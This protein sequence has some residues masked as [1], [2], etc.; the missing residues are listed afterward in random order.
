MPREVRRIYI[1]ITKS[2]SKNPVNTR[3]LFIGFRI[4][5]VQW[6]HRT[7]GHAVTWICEDLKYRKQR[8]SQNA[9]KWRISLI[10]KIQEFRRFPAI[11]ITGKRIPNKLSFQI[12]TLYLCVI[13]CFRLYNY[14]LSRYI[15]C[16]HFYFRRSDIF[17]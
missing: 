4:F 12:T 11:C 13:F 14:F 10:I 5:Y 8:I 3:A 16:V 1:L 9:F 15:W 17:F 7:S 6:I 2:T